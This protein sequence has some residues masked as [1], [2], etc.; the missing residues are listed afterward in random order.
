MIIYNS[1]SV[2]IVECLTKRFSD[3]TGFDFCPVTE[4]RLFIIR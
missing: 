1:F 4:N 2:E 3:V